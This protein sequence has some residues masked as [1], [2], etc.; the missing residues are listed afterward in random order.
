MAN[1]LIIAKREI[2]RVT[3]RF[4]GSSGPVLL[5]VLVGAL[6]ISSLVSRQGAVLGKGMYRVGVPLHSPAIQDSRF[7]TMTVAGSPEYWLLDQK[8]IDVYIDGN[9]VASRNDARSIYATGALKQYLEKQELARITDE[10]EIDRAFPLR[11]EVN[12]LPVATGSV[13]IAQGP[14]L[15]D[16]IDTLR[17]T[18][19]SSAG[20]DS[21]AT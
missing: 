15:S 3:S 18:T 12:Y 9:K 16:L 14:S 10:Y 8:A 11:V 17:S 1:I 20:A 13:S 2:Q 7:K 21:E 5:F 6:V 4:R 19:G